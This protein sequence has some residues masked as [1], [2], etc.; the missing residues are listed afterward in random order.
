MNEGTFVLLINAIT[1]LASCRKLTK[2]IILVRMSSNFIDKIEASEIYELL[3]VSLAS[4][5]VRTVAS[6]RELF[7]LFLTS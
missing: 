7:G 3:Y 2:C 4:A 5:L 6:V 1:N